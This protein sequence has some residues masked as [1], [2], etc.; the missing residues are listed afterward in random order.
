MELS[1]AVLGLSCARLE[2]PWAILGPS[3]IILEPSWSHPGPSWGQLEPSLS[4]PG[5][6]WSHPEPCWSHLGA[7]LGLPKAI[8]NFFGAIL[9]PL[10][11]ILGSWGQLGGI[12]EPSW[13]LPWR[14]RQAAGLSEPPVFRAA[15]AGCAKRKQLGKWLRA[16]Q[17]GRVLHG[18]RAAGPEEGARRELG[19]PRGL[20]A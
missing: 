15:S 7:P 14:P 9:G 16:A 18:L 3:W 13:A 17:H 20:S 8:L 6:S 12:L 1:G 5:P 2:P 10:G 4:Y 11:A 19:G